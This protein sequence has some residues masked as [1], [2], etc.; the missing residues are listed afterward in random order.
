MHRSK[1]PFLKLSSNVEVLLKSRY[2]SHSKYSD[3]TLGLN[4]WLFS[5]GRSCFTA[6]RFIFTQEQYILYSGVILSDRL[7][8]ILFPV[9]F[10]EALFF[11]PPTIPDYES[12]RPG[13]CQKAEGLQ[14]YYLAFFSSGDSFYLL[15]GQMTSYRICCALVLFIS[16]LSLGW[17]CWSGFHVWNVCVSVSKSV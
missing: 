3:K 12:L 15:W 7:N 4:T 2:W 13:F 14:A 17:G 10:K 6:S 5:Q 16:R 1:N 9:W 8:R 11:L